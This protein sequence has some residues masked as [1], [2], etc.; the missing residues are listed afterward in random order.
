MTTIAPETKPPGTRAGLRTSSKLLLWLAGVVIVLTVASALVAHHLQP[1]LRDLA[2]DMLSS[3]FRSDVQI[4]DFHVTLFPF[5][6]LSGKGIV[7]RHHGRTDVPPLISIA[8]FSATASLWS[9]PVRPWHINS[10]TLKG[11]KIQIPPREKREGGSMFG[12]FK[13]RK[14]VTIRIDE[15]SSDDAELDIYPGD[16]Q[17]PVHQFAIH[18]LRMHG[19]GPGHGAPFDA[20]L[21]NAT[22]PGEIKVKGNFGPWQ[23]DDPR[24]TPLSASYTFDKADLNVFKGISGILSSAGKFDG[25]L[26]KIEVQG[27][28]T[29]PDFSVDTANHPVMLKTEFNATVDGTNGDTLLH[30]VIAH[31]LNTTL[32]C[33]GAIV[34]PENKK[35]GKEIKLEV[36]SQTGRIEDLLRLVAKPGKP[37][38]TGSI[39]L[40]TKFD[41]PPRDDTDTK[42]LD[43]LNLDGNFNIP[44]AKFSDPKVEDKIHDFSERAQGHPKD[45]E[46]GEPLS[47]LKSSFRLRNS[48]IDMKNLTF[49]VTGANVKL[50]GNYG[51][52]SED[53]DFHGK[54]HMQA[55][56][57]QAVTGFKS[58]M[59]KPFDS[60]FRKNGVTEIPIKVTGSRSQ[61][62][63]GLDFHHDKDN[64]DEKAKE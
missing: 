18:Q 16:P 44:N 22:P 35:Q 25:V 45:D 30:P 19:I 41:L 38:L 5:L 9:I 42:V 37:L 10:V 62:S 54:L 14:E 28:T 57:S 52:R 61:P 11:L 50:D 21:T 36:A 47:M 60:F 58:W 29:T 2:E 49:V 27:Q 7:L 17:K 20:E 53:L 56:P 32:I 55:K 3:Q 40:K 48:V 43:R 12:G 51:L 63:F 64:K 23:S 24:T 31:F 39:N 15:L 34:K 13:S 6:A 46:T 59:L 26:E 33:N 4:Q 8:E 1:Y